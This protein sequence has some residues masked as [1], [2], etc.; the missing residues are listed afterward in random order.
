MP[1]SA[2]GCTEESFRTHPSRK[3]RCSAAH[4]LSGGFQSPS[5]QPALA[6]SPSTSTAPAP[7]LCRDTEGRAIRS[8][9]R[10]CRKIN[11]RWAQLTTTRGCA[12][13]RRVWEL[14]LRG[15]AAVPGGKQHLGAAL[16]PGILRAPAARHCPRRGNPSGR[17]TYS[18]GSHR[19]KKEI[20]S[21]PAALRE[22]FRELGGPAA[23]TGARA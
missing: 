6:L 20:P 11:L 21:L 23:P 1:M 16:T 15:E 12:G 2:P 8:A 4:R 5:H 9:N 10:I 17:P 18:H 7:Q 13:S 3:P 22:G 14:G 19:Y